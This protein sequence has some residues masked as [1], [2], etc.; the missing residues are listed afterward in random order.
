[1][2]NIYL[3]IVAATL[4]LGYLMP[5]KGRQRKYYIT[6][7][8]LVHAFICAFRYRFLTGD[9]MKY[10]SIFNG[11][12]QYGWFSD[13]VMN[14][15]RNSGFMLFLKLVG[16]LTDGN[17]QVVLIIIA[18]VV[19]LV[20]GYMIWRYSPAPWMS[21]L[22][23]NCMS[24]YLFGFSAIKQSF[25]M[26]F[27][28]LSFIGIMERNLKFYLAMMLLAGL[29]H[30]PALVFLPAYWFCQ[31]KIS[32]MTIALYVLLGIAL[33]LFKDQFVNFIKLFYYEDDEVF[34]FSGELGGRFIMILG[35]TLFSIL[36]S[37]F[38]NP[39]LEKLT[40]LM[41]ISAI[42]QMLAGFDN[43]FTRL[44][45]YYFQMSV[46]YLP[47]LFFQDGQSVQR[48]A[49]QPVFLFNNRSRK[50]LAAF[51]CLFMIWFYWTCNI[52][53]TIDIASDDYLNYRFM[54][55]VK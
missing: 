7:M 51:L 22:V 37:G 38:E 18:A 19:H 54:W 10:Y 13:Q 41:A 53:I 46:F 55:D 16:Y 8:T 42:L 36:I 3:Y 33:Y 9:L 32:P 15:G 27:V 47:M 20:L 48:G 1:M 28:M 6:V 39:A 4:I 23:W 25:A 31:M 14:E 50:L 30:V 45:D 26:A 40:H 11:L 5:Q 34:I 17:F 29:L 44:T 2:R 21:F 24:F 43:I 35:F 12:K 52:N 49:L